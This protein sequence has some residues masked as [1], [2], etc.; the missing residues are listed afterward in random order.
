PLVG[1]AIGAAMQAVAMFFI[2]YFAFR[3]PVGVE[4][5]NEKKQR[6]AERSRRDLAFLGRS[7]TDY[8]V[9]KKA[10]LEPDLSVFLLAD[11]FRVSEDDIIDAVHR[12]HGSTFSDYIDSLRIEHAINL[13]NDPESRY[14]T[15]DPDDLARLAHQC[16]YLERARLESSFQKI[17]QIS[18]RDYCQ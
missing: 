15:D 14:H 9:D 16:G 17:M 11:H 3:T 18:L 4:A 10:Y 1:T 7:L 12:T 5:L 13:M 6:L 8:I 2:G